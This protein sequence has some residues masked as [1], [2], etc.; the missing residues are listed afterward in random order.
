MCVLHNPSF[1]KKIDKN[2]NRMHNQEMKLGL[3]NSK[4]EKNIYICKRYF[5]GKIQNDQL[6]FK[7]L[8]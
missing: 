2:K 3:V 1:L 8:P 5:S 6:V 4:I 7:Q